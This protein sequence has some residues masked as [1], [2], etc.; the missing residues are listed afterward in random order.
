MENTEII[1]MQF[2]L[3]VHLFFQVF[4]EIDDYLGIGLVDGKLHLVWNLGWWSRNE[5]ITGSISDG[6]W[7]SVIVNRVSQSLTLYVDGQAYGSK[8]PGQFSGLN[9]YGMYAFGRCILMRK[10]LS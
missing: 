8:V 6:K 1:I 7:H 2:S 4:S 10:P 3:F 9:T 5:I